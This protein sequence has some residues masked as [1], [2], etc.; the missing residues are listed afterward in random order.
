MEYQMRAA[1]IHD[2][3]TGKVSGQ[4]MML[5]FHGLRSSNEGHLSNEAPTPIDLHHRRMAYTQ[6][7]GAPYSAAGD[8]TIE[9]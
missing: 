2:V 7:A 8:L 1:N 3:L 9:C 5:D 6:P 4:Q